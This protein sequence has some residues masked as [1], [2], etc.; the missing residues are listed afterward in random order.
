MQHLMLKLDRALI[1]RRWMVLGAWIAALAVAVPFAMQQ[2]E[3]L[4]GG[5]FG[6]PGSQSQAVADLTRDDFGGAADAAAEAWNQG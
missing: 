1:R 6:V 3:H 5:G 2:S 4:T